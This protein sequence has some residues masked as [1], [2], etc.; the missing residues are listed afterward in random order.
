MKLGVFWN[1][2][3][4]W[5]PEVKC[6]GC[7]V[8]GKGSSPRTMRKPKCLGLCPDLVVRE[9]TASALNKLLIADII[10]VRNEKGFVHPRL[11]PEF[12]PD[13]PLGGR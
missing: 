4:Q 1:S 13:G 3:S 7:V 8:E 9:F 6:N 10:P 11:S 12:T 2:V 5:T